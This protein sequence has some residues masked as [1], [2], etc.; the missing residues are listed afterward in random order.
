MDKSIVIQKPR[1][2]AK[3]HKSVFSCFTVSN[4]PG[5]CQ[6]HCHPYYELDLIVSGTRSYKNGPNEVTLMP[7]M[8]TVHSPYTY[9]SAN[10][11]GCKRLSGYMLFF[12]SEDIS[13]KLEQLFAD[14][15][16]LTAKLPDDRFG[17]VCGILD[18]LIEFQENHSI[19]HSLLNC[20]LEL[21]GEYFK[22]SDAVDV[23]RFN[24]RVTYISNV[25]R[26]IADNLDGDLRIE[27]LSNHFSVSRAKLSEDFKSY[28]SESIHKYIMDKRVE[29]VKRLLGEKNLSEISLEC[30]FCD[31]SHLIA[32]FKKNTGL[33]PNMYLRNHRNAAVSETER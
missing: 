24:S 25:M 11:S 28:T 17:F 29:R 8:F 4:S 22:K 30:G 26:F 13:P 19:T 31:E 15:S 7:N 16:M 21:L 3:E 20:L 1:V 23:H 9:H 5:F 18:N 32:S 10:S 6:L 33:T 2:V 12:R 27:T 14:C